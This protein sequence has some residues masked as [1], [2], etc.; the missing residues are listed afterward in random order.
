[1][2]R[3]NTIRVAKALIKQ[4]N[5]RD[6]MGAELDLKRALE[7]DPKH[8]T[9]LRRPG[10]NYGMQGRY[11]AAMEMFQKIIDRDPALTELK[12]SWALSSLRNNPRWQEIL[13]LVGLPD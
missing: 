4:A 10:T 1:V 6:F 3:V 12:L 2:I 11:L 9:A 7:I 8:I 5:F 13:K